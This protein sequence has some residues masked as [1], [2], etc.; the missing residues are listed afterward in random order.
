MTDDVAADGIRAPISFDARYGAGVDRALVLGGGGVV[1]V[2]WLTAYLHE[3]ADRGVAVGDADRVVGTS[4]GS[5]LATVIAAGRLDRFAKLI[6]LVE[7]RPNLI[8]RLAPAAKVAPSQQR[9]LELFRHA[10]DA[11]PSV[12]RAIGGAA[13]AAR[14]P[15]VNRLPSSVVLMTQTWR[16]PERSLVVSAVDAYTGERLAF[17]SATRVSRCPVP[18]PPSASV[19]GLFA[20]QPVGDRRAMDG[21]VSG[22]GI[23]TDLVA[24]AGRALVFPIVGDVTEG[25]LTMTPGGTEREI[26]AL[27]RRGHRGRGAPQPVAAHREPDGPGRGARRA[28]ARPVAGGGGRARAGRLLGEPVTGGPERTPLRLYTAVDEHPALAWSWVE[29]QLRDAGTY[30]V[31]SNGPAHPSARP[32]WGIWHDAA[33]HL[34]IGSPTVGAGL[35]R[36]I[37]APACTSTAAPTS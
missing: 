9:A 11:E 32:V 17:D 6:R 7:Q 15:D 16:W 20:P 12:I 24:G 19:P 26:A 33:L 30:W 18:S 31:V 13:L 14:T 23:H 4:A 35:A 27:P 10:A 25:Q 2:A 3:L 22:T 28:R 34:S 8:G 21:G 5:V 29:Q 1:F 36:A 37:R